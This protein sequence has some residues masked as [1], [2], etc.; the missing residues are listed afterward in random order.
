[1]GA[2]LGDA[3]REWRQ[4]AGIRPGLLSTGQAVHDPIP[5]PTVPVSRKKQKVTQ[6]VP[7]QSLGGPSPSFHP[8][9]VAASHQPS[10]STAKRG[11]VPVPKGKKQ[12]PV[13]EE[14]C[15]MPFTIKQD[16]CTLI[17]WLCF[18]SMTLCFTESDV[19]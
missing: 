6:S 14:L 16:A 8:E 2:V 10:S 19:T 18:P 15:Q 11:S 9:A 7:S 13:S 1:M 3:I 5:S 17:V 12:K 4:A